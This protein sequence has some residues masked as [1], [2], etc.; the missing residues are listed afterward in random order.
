[1][2]SIIYDMDKYLKNIK[3]HVTD[4]LTNKYS[5]LGLSEFAIA[6]AIRIVTG[7]IMFGVTEKNH[8]FL[9][10]MFNV[11]NYFDKKPL[12]FTGDC[13][14]DLIPLEYSELLQKSFDSD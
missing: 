10:T 7:T 8:H 3:N 1:M 12:E 6:N 4:T 11:L 5:Y 14:H 13:L 2:K 9:W